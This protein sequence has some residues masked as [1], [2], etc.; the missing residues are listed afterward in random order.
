MAIT[1]ESRKLA[2][3]DILVGSFGYEASIARW[4]RVEKRTPKMVVL[5]ELWGKRLGGGLMYW[6]EVPTDE[7]RGEPFRR[8][9][10][11]MGHDEAVWVEDFILAYLWDGSPEC[12]YN[13][14]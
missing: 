12:C 4:Y 10:H 3:G 14:H 7:E 5:Q 9:V 8:K 13:Y 6:T 1:T 2:E 11:D